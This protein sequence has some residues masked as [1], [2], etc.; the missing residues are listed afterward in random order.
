MR[1]FPLMNFVGWVSSI[2]SQAYAMALKLAGTPTT[3]LICDDFR[4]LSKAIS[5]T[6]LGPAGSLLL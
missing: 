6:Y 3:P 4:L 1:T 2:K 5:P